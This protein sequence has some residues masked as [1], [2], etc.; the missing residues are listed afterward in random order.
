MTMSAD[1]FSA[2]AERLA[3]E[4]G[5]PVSQAALRVRSLDAEPPAD[6]FAPAG[7]SCL[8]GAPLRRASDACPAR[9]GR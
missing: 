5:L 3:L 2:A 1:L 9:C 7:L 6:L 4:T 8:C